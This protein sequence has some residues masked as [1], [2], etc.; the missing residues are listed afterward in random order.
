MDDCE[1]EAIELI[2]ILTSDDIGNISSAL[3][4][5]SMASSIAEKVLNKKKNKKFK[6]TPEF[7]KLLSLK[8]LKILTEKLKNEEFI[9]EDIS[10]EILDNLKEDKVDIYINFIEDVIEFEKKH[11]IFKKCLLCFK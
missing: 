8:I 1:N 7:K 5:I 11:K 9:S 6:T 3:G 2:D 4:V 10:N